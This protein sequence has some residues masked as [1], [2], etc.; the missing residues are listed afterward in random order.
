MGFKIVLMA[1]V[2]MHGVIQHLRE[3]LTIECS[4]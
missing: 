1:R 4:I 3:F 2:N